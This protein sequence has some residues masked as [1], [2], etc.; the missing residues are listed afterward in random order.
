MK[1]G[2]VGA[3]AAGLSAAYE[4]ANAG[5]T[6][7]VYESAPFIGGQ[8]STIEVGGG[9]L[10]R[11][12]HHLFT[13]DTAII[14]L[15]NEM[16][17][18]ASLQ[19]FPSKVGTYA[20]GRVWPTTTPLDILRFGAVPF[21]DRI[22]LGLMA[23]RLQRQKDWRPLEP[24][25]ADEWL[26][27]RLGGK[28][29]EAVWNPL[30]RGKFG[31]QYDKVGMAWLWSKI[32]T[33]VAS[34]KGVGGEKLGYPIK[35]FDEVFDVL[36]AKIES[37][38]SKVLTETT[39]EHVL[40]EGGVAVGLR[41]RHRN[42]QTTEEH[43][44]AVLIT[45]PSYAVP[46]LADLPPGYRGQLESV[47]YLAAVV[48]V[49]ELAHPLT[50]FY[51]MNIADRSVPF[52]G[53]IEHTNLIQRKLYGGNH[54]LYLTNY[55]DRKDPLYLMKPEDLLDVYLPHLKKLNPA[56]DRSWV[57]RM[58]YNS[59]SAAQPVIGAKYSER[60]PSHRTPV[61]RLYLANTTQIYPEDRGTN[62]SIRMGRE[63]GR[64]ILDDGQAAFRDWQAQ[65]KGNR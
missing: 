31:A 1:V 6:V 65:A 45:A 36:R 2:I 30:L 59:L 58:H 57:K 29:Y 7:T 51:W 53:V 22:K 16:G 62:Y 38:G 40:A 25:T 46:D 55:L 61:Q 37:N 5:H 15:M 14:D 41:V 10:E 56:F 49:L 11:G 48:I 19:W 44:D 42:G 13:N 34:R 47:H 23:V 26:R 52:L 9:R 39:V 12:Y 60:I 64:M 27:T 33:R 35:S 32:Q 17:I 8:A 50:T 43:F 3:G 28:A 18:G 20:G 54:I 4:L 24:F 63:V 21:I